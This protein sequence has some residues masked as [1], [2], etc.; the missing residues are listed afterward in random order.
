MPNFDLW[1]TTVLHWLSV[2][3]QGLLALAV[4]A[5]IAAS[6]VP[7]SSEAVLL[8]VLSAQPHQFWPALLVPLSPIPLVV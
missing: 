7:L 8:G 3:E 5:F 2:P 1:I 6:V 4:V